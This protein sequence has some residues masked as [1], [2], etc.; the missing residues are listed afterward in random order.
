MLNLLIFTKTI[1][2]SKCQPD[3]TKKNPYRDSHRERERDTHTQTETFHRTHRCLNLSAFSSTLPHTPFTLSVF[4][5][6]SLF[7]TSAQAKAEAESLLLKLKALLAPPLIFSLRS[8]TRLDFFFEI[9]HSW[10]FDRCTR[11][12]TRCHWTVATPT[13]KGAPSTAPISPATP[14]WS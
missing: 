9:L 1:K 7:L 13:F 2:K 10:V 8:L 14:A 5:L 3:F 6:H 12:F 11:R 4:L